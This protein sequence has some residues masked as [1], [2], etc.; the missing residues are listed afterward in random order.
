MNPSDE[1]V[2][3]GV[4]EEHGA[5]E[6]A[7]FALQKAGFD[8][9][10]I[11]VVGRDHHS[12]GEVVGYYHTGDRMKAWGKRGVFWGG[13]WGLVLGSAFFAV[14]GIGPIAVAGPLVNALVTALGGAAIVGGS[15]VL[16]AALANLGVPEHMINEYESHL[17]GDNVIVVCHG[18]PGA[19]QTALT[20]LKGAGAI[21]AEVHDVSA[22]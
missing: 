8:M 18:S 5:A 19:V 15:S 11:S 17:K 7:V 9:N 20:I 14:P 4:Y 16:G 10:K 3:V 21:H 12:E 6:K 22:G 1:S 13:I 2:A